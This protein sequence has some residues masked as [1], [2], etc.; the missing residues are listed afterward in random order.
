M[1]DGVRDTQWFAYWEGVHQAV[2]AWANGT[3]M[4][5]PYPTPKE[6]EEKFAQMMNDV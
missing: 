6:V 3:P 2:Q 1:S 5:C 4:S